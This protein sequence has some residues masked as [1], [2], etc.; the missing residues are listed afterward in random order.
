M[1]ECHCPH[2][3]TAYPLV[4]QLIDRP[5]RCRQCRQAFRVDAQG[6]V[7]AIIV[8]RPASSRPAP[9]PQDLEEEDSAEPLLGL[10][11]RAQST[12]LE[13]RPSSLIAKG[14]PGQTPR[15][16]SSHILAALRPQSMDM[17]IQSALQQRNDSV[18][19]PA[20]ADYHQ[21]DPIA[22]EQR[23]VSRRISRKPQ[24]RSTE[25]I[26]HAV[27]R[28]LLDEQPSSLSV[29]AEDRGDEST[30]RIPALA[31]VANK[32]SNFTADPSLQV[33]LAGP[34]VACPHCAECYPYRDNLLDRPIRC[35]SCQGVFRVFADGSAVP[36]IVNRPPP[37]TAPAA[38]HSPAPPR[39][40]NTRLI[41]N[42]DLVQSLSHQLAGF[43]QEAA[44]APAPSAQARRPTPQRPD[45][46]WGTVYAGDGAS[47]A[48]QRRLWAVALVGIGLV[49]VALLWGIGSTP[50]HQRV[51]RDWNGPVPQP[52][53]QAR[54][55]HLRAQA[56]P[57]QAVVQPIIGM[58]QARWEPAQRL[59]LP[60][61]HS[62]QSLLAGH[63]YLSEWNLWLPH[64]KEADAQA[65]ID[66]WRLHAQPGPRR[67]DL[68]RYLGQ[69][70]GAITTEALGQA[71]NALPTS[72]H[73]S[74]KER[75][76]A[77]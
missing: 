45:A 44:A 59:V 18:A 31:S 71:V 74:P 64:E 8:N 21:P 58:R 61:L 38:P 37:A 36:V 46:V 42:R 28:G 22:P 35:R 10:S 53:I 32:P 39:R 11:A 73:P 4:A 62:I 63:R 60:S 29:E 1:A 43:A 7:Q 69:S 49:M 47:A 77:P 48:R 5:V 41:R 14:Q 30:K 40:Q 20:V 57:S 65:A 54:I 67:E 12:A 9:K 25:T 55:D 75:W 24:R 13:R 33:P 52:G 2:C 6:V 72:P 34:Q 15:R 76:R 66:H 16:K 3:T 68:R 50:P 23:Q 19:A 56:W 70:H 26:M 27:R 17:G 51:I